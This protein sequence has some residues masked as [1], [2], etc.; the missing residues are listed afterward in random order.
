MTSNGKALFAAHL[1]AWLVAQGIDP[2]AEPVGSVVSVSRRQVLADVRSGAVPA[3]VGS[4]SEL[5]DHVDA[6]Y[7]GN[8]FDWPVLPSETEDDAYQWAFADFWNAVQN[9]LDDW[10]R[11]GQMREDLAAGRGR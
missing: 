6:N 10:I 4:F 9:Q 2:N 1:S 5:H 8:A 3:S 7:Y 11:S